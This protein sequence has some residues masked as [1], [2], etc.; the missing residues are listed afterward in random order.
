[1]CAGGDFFLTFLVLIGGNSYTVVGGRQELAS[2][3]GQRIRYDFET[4]GGRFRERAC[5]RRSAKDL[6]SF[7]FFVR[8]QTRDPT[9]LRYAPA[10]CIGRI[11][12]A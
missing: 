11:D 3:S 12:R 8:G 9:E 6:E 4:T 5:K 1:M 2:N 10:H 7:A